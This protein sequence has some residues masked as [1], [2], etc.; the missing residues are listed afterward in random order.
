MRTLTFRRTKS[1]ATYTTM[2]KCHLL[3]GQWAFLIRWFSVEGSYWRI[4]KDG[5]ELQSLNPRREVSPF[6]SCQWTR[7]QQV[8][9]PL[10]GGWCECFDFK[11]TPICVCL[12]PWSGLGQ[13]EHNAVHFWTCSEC[14][15][16]S[17]CP[18]S[19]E[20]RWMRTLR[21]F[22]W[23][24]KMEECLGIKFGLFLF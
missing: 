21:I 9:E 12:A 2:G 5:Q 20:G 7:R 13:R 4:W 10:V 22:Q 1:Q 6:K 3:H 24:Y 15:C 14:I 17:M 16:E 23:F 18:F 19:E 8:K 11:E